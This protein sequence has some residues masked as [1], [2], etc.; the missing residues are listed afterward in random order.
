MTISVVI[1]CYNAAGTVAATVE[2]ALAQDLPLEVI[3]VND[4]STDGSRDILMGFG[5]RIR[6]IDTPNRGVSAAR[7]TGTEAS[8]GRYIQYLDSDDLLVVGT[9]SARVDA[10]R[11]ANS[12]V[13]HTAWE[14]FTAC[15]AD[16]VAFERIDPDLEGLA[17]D[18]E[19][20]AASSRFW[21]PPA[22]LLY[23]R[24]IVRR[25]G[26]WHPGL[27]VIQ[28]ARFIF[29]AARHGAKFIYVPEVGA[30]YRVAPDSLSRRNKGRFLADCILNAGEI[31]E[32]WRKAGRLTKV[33]ID[34]LAGIWAQCAT[35]TLLE[36]LPGF[37]EA[38]AGFNRNG[39]RRFS[40]E[41]AQLIRSIAGPAAAAALARGLV[42]AKSPS[43]SRM[44]AQQPSRLPRATK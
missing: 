14:K 34:A 18:S 41:A 30:R 7:T 21:A 35:G 20:A 25:I 9:L 26:A 33:R 5:D 39:S 13:A 23:T 40:F 10:L 19:A 3:V 6:V 16:I 12:D 43:V 24:E 2:S 4:G 31:E 38:R 29:D 28:D 1:P 11:L 44:L 8:S 15:G 17:G 36:G 27:P 37:E 42:R 22:A 32:I